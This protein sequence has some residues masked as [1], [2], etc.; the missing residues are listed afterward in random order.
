MK[1]TPAYLLHVAFAI[2]LQSET[3]L[4]TD[5]QAIIARAE[6]LSVPEIQD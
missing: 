6:G 5:E 1:S 2:Q 3:F 4:T